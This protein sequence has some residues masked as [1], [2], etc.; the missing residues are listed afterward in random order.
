MRGLRAW[1]F[2]LHPQRQRRQ[3][4]P[5]FQRGESEIL[6]QPAENSRLGIPVQKDT[7]AVFVGA[8][9]EATETLN[10]E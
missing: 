2:Q 9:L 8:D 4:R 3:D 6:L 10:V 7:E 5:R 1:F